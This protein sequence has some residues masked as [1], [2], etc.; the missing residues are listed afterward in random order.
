MFFQNRLCLLV[1]LGVALAS[2]PV[3]ADTVVF[4]SGNYV[5]AEP[6]DYSI[7]SQQF[8]A[9]AFSLNATTQI[10]SV[11]GV[12]S[13]FSSGD[14]M[15]AAIV[16]TSSLAAMPTANINNLASIALAHT[17]L[18]PDGTDQTAALPVTLAAGTYEVIFGFGLFGSPSDSALGGPASS[19]LATGQDT[20]GSPNLFN[21]SNG[22]LSWQTLSSSDVRIDVNA[23]PLPAGLPLLLSGLLGV[24]GVLRRRASR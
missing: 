16:S 2:G 13:Q 8:V 10:S 14:P 6:G 19:G 15:F 21:T 4:A 11:G 24:G 18:T 5:N 23:V 12:F 7:D 17:T 22:G 20:I 1:G 9:A 3:L